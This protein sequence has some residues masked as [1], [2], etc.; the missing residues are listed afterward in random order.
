M[1]GEQETLGTMLYIKDI[2]IP[3]IARIKAEGRPVYTRLETDQERH[4][5]ICGLKEDGET[6]SSE[7]SKRENELNVEYSINSFKCSTC[8]EHLG[9]IPI[10]I[11]KLLF[12]QMEQHRKNLTE[13]NQTK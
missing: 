10:N 12:F 7:I 3:N 5:V 9:E 13:T 8:K 11:E 1:E 2:F 4:R 6:L